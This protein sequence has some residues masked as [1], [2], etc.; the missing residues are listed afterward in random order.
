M[1]SRFQICSLPKYLSSDANAAH[2]SI[3]RSALSIQANNNTCQ[4]TFVYSIYK[5]TTK[6][7]R[8]I[9]QLLW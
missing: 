1:L 6:I 5:I 3:L 2:L 9:K 4:Y 8:G 7:T